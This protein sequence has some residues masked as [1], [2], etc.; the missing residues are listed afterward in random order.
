MA[1]LVSATLLATTALFAAVILYLALLRHLWL[2]G[3][4]I[5]PL[6]F[7]FPPADQLRFLVMLIGLLALLYGA[8]LALRL[9]RPGAMHP[10]ERGRTVKD[11]GR[12]LAD[13]A[14]QVNPSAAREDRPR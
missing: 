9:L 11:A 2:A 1:D 5:I 8:P 7:A 6:S 12:D 10:H 4:A 14:W 13:A 3:A